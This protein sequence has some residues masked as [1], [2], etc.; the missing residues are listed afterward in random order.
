ML[1]GAAI[2]LLIEPPKLR[3]RRPRRAPNKQR[4]EYRGISE[5]SD[6]SGGSEICI[7]SAPVTLPGTLVLALVTFAPCALHGSTGENES[8]LGLR[9]LLTI[10]LQRL[11]EVG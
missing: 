10:K 1:L 8:L 6:C 3:G 9:L 4:S 5:S 11:Q 2:S 7:S